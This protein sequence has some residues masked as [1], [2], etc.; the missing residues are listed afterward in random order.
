MPATGESTARE[1]RQQVR[2][3]DCIVYS[4]GLRLGAALHL[5]DDHDETTRLPL[6]IPCSGF[7]GLR[8]IHPARFA[9]ALTSRGYAC[10]A[11]DYRGFADSEGVRNRVLLGE[12]VRDIRAATAYVSEDERVD[13]QR[14][15]LLGWGVGAGIVIDAAWAIPYVRGLISINGFYNGTRFQ[16]AHRTPSELRAFIARV[17]QA[18]ALRART[19]QVDSVDPFDIHPLDTS[20]RSYVDYFLKAVR[21]YDAEGYDLDFAESLLA[22]NPGA[23][24]SEFTLP[25]LIA[26]G[27]ENDLYPYTEALSLYRAWRGEKALH[28]IQGAGHT[29]WMHDDNEHFLG[30][31][32]AISDW[33]E[34]YL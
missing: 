19:G 6:V 34:S 5:P 20:S 7:T 21:G 30:L 10:F 13:P 12:Q 14:I 2:S 28:R 1:G 9:R 32:A 23:L 22:W 25:I 27:E 18:R 3:E 16:A 8:H 29:E 15:V 26:H 4:D 24:A 31:M 11:F 17:W 33:L